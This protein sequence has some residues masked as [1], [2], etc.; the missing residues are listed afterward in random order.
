LFTVLR[1]GLGVC[2]CVCYSAIFTKTNRIYRIFS[3]CMKG[4]QK[5]AYIS[6]KSQLVICSGKWREGSLNK[7]IINR[8]NLRPSSRA[9]IVFWVNIL[10]WNLMVTQGRAQNKHERL[11]FSSFHLL[12][13]F[14][15]RS[16]FCP[17][18][19]CDNLAVYWYARRTGNN[20]IYREYLHN[21]WTFLLPNKPSSNNVEN[22]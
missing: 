12:C 1:I 4:N 19:W 7:Q 3:G 8:S 21:I 9:F 14:F 13:I 20:W 11:K 15:I 2:L 6:P 10:S 17:T 18:P 5:P 22:C 16:H